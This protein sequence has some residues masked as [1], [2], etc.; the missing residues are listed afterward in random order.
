LGPV[1]GLCNWVVY[2]G[3]KKYG[4]INEAKDLAYKTVKLFGDDLMKTGEMHEFYHPETGETVFTKGFQ[5][6]NL[7]SVEMLNWLKTFY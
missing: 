1:W 3:M 6:W 2:E 4:Y 7:F 5:S